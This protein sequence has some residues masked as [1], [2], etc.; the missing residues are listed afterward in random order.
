MRKTLLLAVLTVALMTGFAEDARAYNQIGAGAA[1]CGTW[2]E[3]RRDPRSSMALIDISWV[4][5]F[6]SGIG[7]TSVGSADPMRGMDV[8]GISAWIDNYCRAHPIKHISDAAGAFFE[9]HPR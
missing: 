8:A 4:T 9:A 6:L 7:F 3:D 1:S 5:G 2:L